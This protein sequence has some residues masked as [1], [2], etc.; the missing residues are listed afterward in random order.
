MTRTSK[1]IIWMALILLVAGCTQNVSTTTAESSPATQAS[2]PP[3]VVTSAPPNAVS[4]LSTNE[5]DELFKSAVA[6]LEEADSFQISAHS[7]RSYMIINSDGTLIK[8]VY[9]EFNSTYTILRKPVF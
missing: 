8:P 7:V 2:L 4:T 9:G 1:I 6:L 5:T 3:V